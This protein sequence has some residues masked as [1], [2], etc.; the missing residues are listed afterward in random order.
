MTG[1]SFW[2]MIKEAGSEWWRDQAPRLGAAL[3][4]YT[5]FS[6][7][8]LLL[9][10][11]AVAGLIFG[12]KAAQGELAG[13]LQNFVGPQGASAIQSMLAQS[14]S[15]RSGVWATIVSSV[16]LLIGAMSLFGQLQGS[17]NSIWQVQSQSN[18]WIWPMIR[19][20]LLSFLMVAIIALLLLASLILSAVLNAVI[21][22][23]PAGGSAMIYEI[24]HVLV[25]LAL[26]TFLFAM[27]FRFMP[28]A[29]ISWRNVWFGAIVTSI[30]FN[31]GKYLIG[32]YL[33]RS[34]RGLDLWRRRFACRPARLALLLGPD[35][36]VRRRGDQGACPIAGAG[37]RRGQGRLISIRRESH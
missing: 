30:L 33:G 20:R 7:A 8:P 6:M 28:D 18:G 34:A 37:Q 11:V 25:S 36:S 2:Q 10:C 27:L 9:L 17:F 14:S 24:V 32:L 13:Q 21:R 5:I 19:R 16:L 15:E 12:H 35:P 23:L 31:I 29:N 1:K 26:M 3:A 4:Y 22:W